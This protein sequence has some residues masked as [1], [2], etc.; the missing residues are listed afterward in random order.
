LLQT[1]STAAAAAA[2]E[3]DDT[4]ADATGLSEEEISTLVQ[5]SGCSR[6]KAI[7]ALRKHGSVVD[8]LLALTS[9]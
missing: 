1:N 7:K 6:S 5:N 3:E 9:T 4:E 2:P 8:A